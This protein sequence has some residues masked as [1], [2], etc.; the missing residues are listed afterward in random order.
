MIFKF[1]LIISDQHV[2]LERGSES[3]TEYESQSVITD[4]DKDPEMYLI[5]LNPVPDPIHYFIYYNSYC[6]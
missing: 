4:P 5:R 6:Q 2:D 1:Y 3:G